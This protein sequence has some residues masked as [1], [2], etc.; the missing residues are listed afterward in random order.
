MLEKTRNRDCRNSGMCSSFK[1]PTTWNPLNTARAAHK[2]Q[3]P[4]STELSCTRDVCPIIRLVVRHDGLT[5]NDRSSGPLCM[6]SWKRVAVRLCN[7]GQCKNELQDALLKQ[8]SNDIG[9][10]SP[11]LQ[12]LAP[13]GGR[14]EAVE[15]EPVSGY[16]I[17][18]TQW[19]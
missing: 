8:L 6:Q 16:T 19:L 3:T 10:L 13:L 2:V 15:E 1:S 7:P 9:R 18:R 17:Q 4:Q 12:V 11:Y 14:S 5:Y